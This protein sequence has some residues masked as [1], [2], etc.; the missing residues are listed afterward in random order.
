VVGFTICKVLAV[1]LIFIFVY[2]LLKLFLEGN[3]S[4]SFIN[5]VLLPLIV[6][7]MVSFAFSI[8]F[9]GEAKADKANNIPPHKEVK[10]GK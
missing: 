3:D 2:Y 1:V 5:D 8:Y 4:K 7:F 6:A 10:N 9:I